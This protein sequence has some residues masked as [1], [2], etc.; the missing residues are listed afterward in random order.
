MP[1]ENSVEAEASAAGSPAASETEHASKP[2]GRRYGFACIPCKQRKVKCSGEQPACSGCQRKGS[3]CVWPASSRGVESQLL[4]EANERIRQLEGSLVQ[5]PAAASQGQPCPVPETADT[6]PGTVFNPG[7]N[8]GNRR[9]K[10]SRP[11]PIHNPNNTKRLRRGSRPSQSASS[12]LGASPQSVPNSYPTLDPNS[13]SRKSHD[14]RFASSLWYQV[15]IGE[16]GEVVYNGPTSRF[17]AGTLPNHDNQE[18]AEDASDSSINDEDADDNGDGSADDD[19]LP[20]ELRAQTE[21]WHRVY[22]NRETLYEA[23]TNPCLA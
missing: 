10:T 22:R 23:T 15:G 3:E 17:H 9:M 7:E 20:R 8:V 5:Q 11:R 6:E 16:D 4:R 14:S 19:R 21:R 2:K 12:Q 1:D 13:E 18:E